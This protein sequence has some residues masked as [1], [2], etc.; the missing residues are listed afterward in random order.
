MIN[1][2]IEERRGR[3]GDIAP[4]LKSQGGSEGMGRGNQTMELSSLTVCRCPDLSV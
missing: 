2:R 4:S 1:P 3:R